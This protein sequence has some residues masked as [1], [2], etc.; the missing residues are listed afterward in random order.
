MHDQ[1]GFERWLLDEIPVQARIRRIHELE[2][3]TGYGPQ[4]TEQYLD[5]LI[6]VLSRYADRDPN[7]IRRVARIPGE[8]EELVHNGPS[9]MA[10]LERE[11]RERERWR[12]RGTCGGTCCTGVG[13]DP[14]TC[15]APD[16][17]EEQRG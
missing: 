16:D 2:K 1:A 5:T 12:C 7:A 15:P 17:E 9:L 11:A 4:M 6:I 14:C 3:R 10:R 8:L 13:S